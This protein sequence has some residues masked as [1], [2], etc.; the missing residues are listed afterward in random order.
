MIELGHNLDLRVVAEGVETDAVLGILRTFGC[1]LVQGFLLARPMPSD[2]I[3][4]WID[5]P[6]SQ[7]SAPSAA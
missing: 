6:A 1:D 4:R 7:R 3:A 5:P 2:Q